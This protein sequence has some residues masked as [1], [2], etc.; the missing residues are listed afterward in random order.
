ML[1]VVAV[2]KGVLRQR[3]VPACLAGRTRGEGS[4]GATPFAVE[5]HDE[6]RRRGTA[7]VKKGTFYNGKR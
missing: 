4:S 2:V 1:A 3:H 5:V 7:R 6:P